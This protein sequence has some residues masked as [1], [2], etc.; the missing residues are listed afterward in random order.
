[1][2]NCLE[3][4]GK[5]SGQVINFEKSTIMF[6]PSVPD[7]LKEAIRG[8]L[9]VTPEVPSGKYLGLPT[10]VGRNKKAAFNF[11][12]ERIGHRLRDWNKRILSR[13]GKEVL[14]KSIILRD[15]RLF[16]SDHLL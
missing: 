13:V 2:K 12:K 11:I 16:I 1:M 10:L 6:N 5:A 7:R 4:Y 14:L 3:Q 8:I 15:E 9:Q